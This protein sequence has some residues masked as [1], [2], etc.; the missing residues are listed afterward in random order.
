MTMV[1]TLTNLRVPEH[2]EGVLVVG[3]S[4]GTAVSPLWARC[5]QHLPID[6]AVVGWDLPG[7]GSCPTHDE[8]FTVEDLAQAVMQAT[9]EIRDDATGMVLHAG[10]SLG[11]AVGLALAIDHPQGFDG[12]VV[13]ASG[14]KVGEAEGWH[15]RAD[16]VRR[17]G[18][19]VMVEASAQRWFAPG[20]IE[21]D[22]A[23]AAALLDSLQEA[24]RFSYARCCEALAAFDVRD[25]LGAVE[26]PV[27]AL[28]GE[29]DPV[30][31]IEMAATVAEGTG[32]TA[33][34]IAG[35]AHLPPADQPAATAHEITEFLMGPVAEASAW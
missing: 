24:D 14:A 17:A 15:E 35:A 28:A 16:L 31:S 7:H 27:L 30:A 5:V 22:P 29:H 25:G 18:T 2:P 32:G 33:R 19:P 9:E 4:L 34:T 6:L 10:V 1:L 20:A 13:I 23:T 26:V 8:P 21:R 11:G 12:V 3:P